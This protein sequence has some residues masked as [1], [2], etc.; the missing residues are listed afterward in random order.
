MSIVRPTINLDAQ[1]VLEAL[2]GVSGLCQKTYWSKT[3]KG[4]DLL[5]CHK[6]WYS[7]ALTMEEKIELTVEIE[8][9]TKQ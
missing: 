6:A 9:K 4:Y 1:E 8:Q 2:G 5:G 3:P 7:Q